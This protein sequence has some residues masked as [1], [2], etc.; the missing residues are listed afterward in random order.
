MNNVEEIVSKA[1]VETDAQVSSDGAGSVKISVLEPTTIN[2]FEAGDVDVEKA[3]LLYQAKLKSENL[4]GNAYLE[5]LLH[6]PDTGDFY[7][8]GKEAGITGTSDWTT[9][10]ASTEVEDGKNPDAVKLNLVVDGKGTVWVDDVKLSKVVTEQAQPE[11]SS[12]T[13]TTETEQ[14]GTE[15]AQEPAA[16]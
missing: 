10:E 2:L 1:N 15:P 6:Y 7:V 12:Q 13:T 3:K 16:Q 11:A 5:M 14:P 4:E 9:V 8:Q